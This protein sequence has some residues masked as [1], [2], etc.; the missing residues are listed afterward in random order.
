[1]FCVKCEAK[2]EE[3]AAF[4]VQC[5]TPVQNP[6]QP[7][8]GQPLQAQGQPQ[9]VGQPMQGQSAAL[10][11]AI[12]ILICL[13]AGSVSSFLVSGCLSMLPAAMSSVVGGII[14]FLVIAAYSAL[15]FFLIYKPL[16]AKV[17]KSYALVGGI[18]FSV[19]IAIVLATMGVNAITSLPLCIILAAAY[20]AI[21]YAYAAK[22]EKK[23]N[24]F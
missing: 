6:A 20:T 4:C 11:V 24:R 23:K 2:I 16:E 22:F 7:A 13:V 17:G 14:F 10:K 21:I 19:V 18:A 3:G 8:Q 1:M 12:R 15:L 5:G 9:P